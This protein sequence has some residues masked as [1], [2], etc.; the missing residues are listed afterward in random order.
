MNR[1][2]RLG[3][4]VKTFYL[5]RAG[6]EG[7]EEKKEWQ[8]GSKEKAFSRGVGQDSVRSLAPKHPLTLRETRIALD[9]EALHQEIRQVQL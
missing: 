9:R 3:L 7:A 1:V 2:T 5:A 8:D 4:L 6:C